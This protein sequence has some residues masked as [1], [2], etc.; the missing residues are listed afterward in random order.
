[1]VL[2]I[3]GNDF[4]GPGMDSVPIDLKGIIS[5]NHIHLTFGQEAFMQPKFEHLIIYPKPF[6]SPQYPKNFHASEIYEEDGVV[7]FSIEQLMA[8]T[9]TPEKNYNIGLHEF[10]RTFMISNPEKNFPPLREE[11]WNMLEQI[12]GFSKKYID[13]YMNRPD[14]APLPVSISH[15]F[16]FPNAFKK[17]WPDRYETYRQLFEIDPSNREQPIVIRPEE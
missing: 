9:F 15:F 7:I 5:A 4:K 2:Y 10:A 12:S 14:V 1:M 3:L 13:E 8:S 16:I 17:I 11:D 6:P